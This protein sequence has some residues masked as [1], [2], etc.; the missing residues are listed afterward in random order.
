MAATPPSQDAYY[1]S[2]EHKFDALNRLVQISLVMNSTLKLQPLLQTIMEAAAEISGAEAASILL[3]DKNTNE[4]RF[5]AALSPDPEH[6]MGMVVPLEG[7]IAGTII[8]ENRAIIIDD[9]SRD[10]RHFKNVDQAIEFQTRAILGVPMRIRDDLIGVLEVLNKRE[11]RFNDEDLRHITILA[12]Q[13]AV[14]IENARLI[15]ALRKAYD[16]LAQVNKLK[17]DFIAIASHELRTPLGVVLGY[18]AFLKEETEG[19]M[20]EH[21]EAVLN[22][23]LH[24]RNLIE[25][26]TNLRYVQIDRAELKFAVAPLNRILG[27]AHADVIEL[28]EAK[29]QVLLLEQPAYDIPVKVDAVRMEMAITNVLNNAVKF[30][31]PGGLIV[32]SAEE[33]AREVWVR[34]QDNGIGLEPDHLERIFD[35]FYQVEDPMRRRHGGLGL[36]LTIARAIV[37]RHDGRIWAESAGLGLGSTFTVAL[38]LARER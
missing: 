10:P 5:T 35:Q 21:A 25:D 22:S 38:P 36:G 15:A 18:A 9:A 16:D 1:R 26:M 28:A 23:A 13:A 29:E 4:L 14:A 3:W 17:N 6:L 20:G 19:E 32:L 33:Q 7:S 30:T 37:E 12:S 34:V 2:L 8:S 24:L 11:G 27:A 31:P